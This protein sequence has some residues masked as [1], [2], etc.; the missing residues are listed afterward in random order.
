IIQRNL[1]SLGTD[2][3]LAVESVNL[4][5]LSNNVKYALTDQL[6]T[7]RGLYVQSLNNGLWRTVNYDAF[8]KPL[9]SL[10]FGYLYNGQYYDIHTGLQYAHARYYD[11]V[12][13]RFISQDSLGFAAGDTNLYRR[14]GNSPANGTDPTGHFLQALF[15]AAIGAVAYGIQS[16]ITGKW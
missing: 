13:H 12:M 3:I 8:G 7:V 16:A 1:W 14:V 6:G 5:N 2:Q 9:S 15:G 11:P 4:G 10:G